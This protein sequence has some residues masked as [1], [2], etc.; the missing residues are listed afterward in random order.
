MFKEKLGICFYEELN[1]KIFEKSNEKS[2]KDLI[3]ESDKK[4]I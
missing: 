1:G 2:T 3:E 4:T